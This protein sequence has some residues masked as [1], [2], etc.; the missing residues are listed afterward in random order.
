MRRAI[1]M[2][3]FVFAWTSLVVLVLSRLWAEALAQ[4][5]IVSVETAPR[6][7]VAIVFGGGV[8]RNG[9]PTRALANRLD[10]ALVLYRTGRVK[11]LLLSGS[12]NYAG[13]NEVESMANY[14]MARGVP[15]EALLLDPNGVRTLMTCREAVQTFGLRRA[16]LVTHR[17]H[18]PRALV[19]CRTY[20]LEALGVP[21]LFDRA[22]LWERLTFWYGRESLATVRALLDLLWLHPPSEG[23]SGKAL[24]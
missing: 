24:P 13:Y 23:L 7:E 8:R 21:T 3:S 17:Y 20:G 1:Y 5:F 9:Q 15:R 12:I 4:P 16:L 22:P 11:R 19:L 10:T 18:L 14:L 2:A 6:W